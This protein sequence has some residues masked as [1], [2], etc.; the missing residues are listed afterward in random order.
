MTEP[1]PA[2]LGRVDVARRLGVSPKTVDAWRASRGFPEPTWTVG[3]R[4]AWSWPV[5]ARWLWT[6]AP[7]RA[8]ELGLR[9]PDSEVAVGQLGGSIV[10]PKIESPDPDPVEI[11]AARTPDI[12]PSEPPCSHPR[13]KH[14][15]LGYATMCECGERIR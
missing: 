14:R 1:H 8:A 10:G 9:M 2:V 15:Q 11:P 6:A 3:D 5:V 7:N 12:I 13:E 4:P